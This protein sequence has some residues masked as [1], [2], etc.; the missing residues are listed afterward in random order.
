MASFR[1]LPLLSNENQQGLVPIVIR[2]THRR[3]HRY[4]ATPYV[5][6]RSQL[7]RD[8]QVKESDKAL[9]PKLNLLW[10]DVRAILDELSFRV[11]AY[12]P[13]ELKDYLR[14]KLAGDAEDI[15]FF[16]FA[17]GYIA[18]IRQAQPATATNHA[19]ALGNLARYV[20]REQLPARDVTERFLY[21]YLEW[22]RR[23]GGR[24]GT[25]LGA[26]GQSLYLGS[27]RRLLNEA[28][29]QHNDY[30]RGDVPLP[31]RP[32]ERFKIQKAKP[33][34]TADVKALTVPQLLAIRGYQPRYERDE[35]AR[36]C[37]LLSL[38]LCGMNSVDLYRCAK[39][40]GGV[41]TYQ[42]SKTA[43]RRM[44]G[45]VVSVRMEPE[46]EPLYLKYRGTKKVFA[47]SERYADRSTFSYALN[48]GL[49]R[50]GEAVGVPELTFYY[51]RHSWATLAS[52]EC[53]IPIEVVGMALGHS[54][55]KLITNVYIKKDW[56]KVYEANRMVLDLLI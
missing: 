26:R 53:R 52:N 2:L 17:R 51:A 24:G 14:R 43:E 1:I 16:A 8:G 47:F 10:N 25:P 23:E 18:S 31:N 11:N 15:D 6:H 45:A 42:R 12:T 44:D 7:G 54:D 29:Q 28:Q 36:D 22:M 40:S 33:Q 49:K 27:I 19:V 3:I 50:V 9:K 46:A 13:D 56:G 41:L 48:S 4:I 5:A 37:F 32:F 39:L 20:G 21:A 30:D 38:Y 55:A 35:L 34:K